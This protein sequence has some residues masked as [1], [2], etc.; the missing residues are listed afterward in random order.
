MHGLG[1]ERAGSGERGWRQRQE[2]G[3]AAS[4]NLLLA[5]RPGIVADV[6]MSACFNARTLACKLVEP[7]DSLRDVEIARH[8][9]V[10]A[11]EVD[12]SAFGDR[13][14]VIGT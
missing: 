7:T 2:G 6:E 5:V 3:C 1:S 12:A 13:A 10:D 14:K 8:E 11:R 9:Q 4:R